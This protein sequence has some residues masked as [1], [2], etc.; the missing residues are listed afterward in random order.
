MIL[1]DMYLLSLP[2]LKLLVSTKTLGVS[3][4]STLKLQK[5]FV[6]IFRIPPLYTTG[7]PLFVPEPSDNVGL[8]PKLTV[9]VLAVTADTVWFVKLRVGS[10]QRIVVIVSIDVTP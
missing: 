6:P 10:L 4:I 3:N 8:V 5:G 2:I 1:I 9:I 7:F